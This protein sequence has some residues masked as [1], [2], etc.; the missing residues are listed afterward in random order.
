MEKK[1]E[2]DV[3]PSLKVFERQSVLAIEKSSHLL[4]DNALK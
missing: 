1:K 4:T 2:S 3:I